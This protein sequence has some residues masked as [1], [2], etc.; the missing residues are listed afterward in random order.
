MG[1]RRVVEG[2]RG[3]LGWTGLLDCTDLGWDRTGRTGL[4]ENS[5]GRGVRW[6]G[7]RVQMLL[8]YYYSDMR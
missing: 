1:Q 4:D 2:L 6:R 7:V 3:G 8:Y 5:G